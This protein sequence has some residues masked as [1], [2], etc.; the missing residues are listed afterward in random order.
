MEVAP[1]YELPTL[2]YPAYTAYTPFTALTVSEQKGFY[3]LINILC[4]C[5]ALNVA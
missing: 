1:C 5:V 2:L 3:A 4:G